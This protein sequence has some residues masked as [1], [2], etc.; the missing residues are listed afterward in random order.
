MNDIG[1]ELADICEEAARL[2]L[3]LWRTGVKVMSKADESPVTE[4]DHRGEALI[5]K[6][7]AERFPGVPVISEEDA[8]QFGVPEAIGPRFFLVDPLDGTKAFV[9]GDPNFTVNIGLIENGVPVAGA[10]AAPA[11]YEV[12]YT[13]GAGALKRRSGGAAQPIRV[14]PWPAGEAMALTSHTMKDPVAEELAA[15]YRF[16]RRTAMDSSIKFC[17]IAE[18]AAD[19]YPRHGPTM[20]WDVAAGHAVLVAAGGRMATPEGRAFVYGKADKGF[21]NGW[22]VARGG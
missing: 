4:A 14:R 22:F 9:R 2:I 11:T 7:L 18:G 20:E 13:Q 21:R 5:L 3:P 16:D 17:R 15:T 6:A 19:I 12:W 10:V 1:A 8:S